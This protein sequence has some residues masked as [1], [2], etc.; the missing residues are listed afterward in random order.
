M[1]AQREYEAWFLGGWT[2]PHPQPESIRD[3]KGAMDRLLAGYT[4][5][6]DQASLSASLDLAAA[7]RHCR[8]F[9]RLVRAFGL[10]ASRMGAKPQA[11]PPPG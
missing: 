1:I 9:R 5:T 11:W 3:A 8:S 6:V 7:H 4:P 10:L 2:P